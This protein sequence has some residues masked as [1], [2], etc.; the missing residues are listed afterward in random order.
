MRM[1]LPIALLVVCFSSPVSAD[2]IT[3]A[4]FH[5]VHVANGWKL[6]ATEKGRTVLHTGNGG[7]TWQDVTPAAIRTFTFEQGQ[8]H[9]ENGGDDFQMAC[10]DSSVVWIVE[11]PSINT[12][13][14]ERSQDNGRHWQESRFNNTTGYSLVVSFEDSEHGSI[15]AI[16]DMASGST[17]KALY[18]TADGGQTWTF[19]TKA[20]PDHIDPTGV[21]F[22]NHLE[23]WLTAG[24][25]GSDDLP[26]YRTTDG[27]HHWS[28]Q[29][30]DWAPL[31]Q[32]GYGGTYPP[33]FFGPRRRMGVLPIS[34]HTHA[35]ERTGLALYQT[36]NGG[37]TWR[38]LRWLRLADRLAFGPSLHFSNLQTGWALDSTEPTSNLWRTKDGGKHWH[39]FYPARRKSL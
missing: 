39:I 28:L 16:S 31:S 26:F 37:R 8:E 29:E 21:V 2:I 11:K 6:D 35:P 9:Q 36:Q 15:L 38:F 4:T 17:R 14:V 22:R 24:Y 5:S 33:A 19:V 12:V 32:D 20:M 10:L 23:G 34:F 18:R 3:H 30:L 27:G 1:L 25:H 7:R 13:L